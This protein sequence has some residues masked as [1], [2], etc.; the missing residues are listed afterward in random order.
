MVE[1]FRNR[2]HD[3]IKV[4]VP[5]WRK[6]TSRPETPITD[7]HILD[8]LEKEGV[9]LYTPSRKISGRRI[10]CYDDRYIIRYAQLEGG[11]IVSND[12]FR[13][14]MQ[15]DNEWRRVIE[16]RLLQFV[17][18]NDHFMPPDDP[19]GK[20]GPTLDNFL[21]KDPREQLGVTKKSISDSRGNSMPVCPHL[22]NCTFGRKCRYYHPDREPQKVEHAGGSG[23]SS[24]GSYTPSTS[25]R[26]A[27]PSPSPD[28][29]SQGMHSSSK[30][31][32]EDLYGSRYSS[33][34]DLYRGEREKVLSGEISSA[35]DVNDLADKFS[36]TSIGQTSPTKHLYNGGD[37]YHP[38]TGPHLSIMF[39]H[40]PAGQVKTAPLPDA[41]Y[42]ILPPLSEGSGRPQNRTFPLAHP[43]AV[44]S[45]RPGNM[46]EEHTY[47]PHPHSVVP[48]DDPLTFVPH[49]GG[50]GGSQATLLP[51][52]AC[53]NQQYQYTPGPPQ[54]YP[55]PNDYRGGVVD[56]THMKRDPRYRAR[57]GVVNQ[58]PMYAQ[59]Q[60]MNSYDPPPPPSH[61]GGDQ[62]IPLHNLH[63]QHFS[64][65]HQL[66]PHHQGYVNNATPHPHHVVQPAYHHHQEPGYHRSDAPPTVQQQQQHPSNPRHEL[67]RMAN[68]VLPKCDERIRRVMRCHPELTTPADYSRLV[69][70]VHQMD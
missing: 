45:T 57:M 46:T 6:E 11:V 15:E 47:Q 1:Y 40:P 27:T 28:N 69:D 42:A 13:D 70:L 44:R 34:D 14:L 22:G 9:L 51:R 61:R 25:S 19:L 58:Q 8:S 64:P 55:Q 52:D 38:Q 26:S 36:Q 56:H 7:Q 17:F 43:Q 62:S 50:V 41:S 63:Q 54:G 21:R 31:S 29:R 12:Q 32:R 23:G 67:F 60:A 16:Q 37:S 5:E 48:Y 4:F 49:D 18:A 68:A 2:G 33:S 10:V 3:H 53:K 24:G 65:N 66:I 59:H 35:R 30:S 20:S 39:P